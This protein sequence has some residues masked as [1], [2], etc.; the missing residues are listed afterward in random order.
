[1]TILETDSLLTIQDLRTLL[2]ISR[3]TIYRLLDEG[4]IPPPIK[5]GRRLLRWKSSD[6]KNFIEIQLGSFEPPE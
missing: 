4:K 5:I 2:K 6:M 3:T 1:M